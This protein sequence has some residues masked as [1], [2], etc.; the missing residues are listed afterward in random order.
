MVGSRQDATTSALTAEAVTLIGG[1]WPEESF[2][3]EAVVRYRG[4]PAAA[5]IRPGPAGS[6]EATISFTGDGPI[7]APGQ[8]VVF[9]RG[10]EVLGGGTIAQVVRGAAAALEPA[11][12]A[13]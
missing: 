8:A 1:S 5:E 10:D 7:A 2:I 9:Y 4:T 3:C 6:G 11:A 12:I 13:G